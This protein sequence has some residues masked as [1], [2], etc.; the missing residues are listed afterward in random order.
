MKPLVIVTRKL[1][2]SVELR[3]KEL[4]NVRLNGDDKVFTKEDLIAAVKEAHVLVTTVTDEIS[5]GVLSKAAPDLKM[6]ANYGVGVDHIDLMSARDKRIIITNTPGVL[7]E[8]TADM[9][10]LLILGITRRMSEGE[11]MLRAGKWKIWSPIG[12][13]GMRLRDKNLGIIG[14]G[15]IG[16][17]LALRAKTF[18]LNIHYYNRQQINEDL[19]K[20]LC[21]TYWA[22]LDQMITQMNIIS[23]N[24]S[25]TPDTHHIMSR[26][27]IGLMQ[28]NAYLIN[29][30]RGDVVDEDA[31]IE[32]L[33][34]KTIAGAGLDVYKNE[35]NINPRLLNLDNV[36]LTP[37]MGSATDE[38]RIA[39]GEKVIINVKTFLDGHSPGDRVLA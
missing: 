28:K 3:M 25:S 5:G 20:S 7:T 23:L 2:A 24:C 39:M 33:E 4:F 34:E 35:P 31:L 17:A 12:M 8:D 32:A 15:R 27:R 13:L 14:M 19:E 11:K 21:A 37:H 29:T 9:A 36:L 22:S 16:Q 1:P 26:R 18:G 10:M 38:A 6:I 30:T